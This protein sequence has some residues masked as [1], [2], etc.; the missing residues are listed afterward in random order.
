MT[1]PIHA[2]TQAQCNRNP[3]VRSWDIRE[4]HRRDVLLRTAY[5][6]IVAAFACRPSPRGP[7]D[8][9]ATGDATPWKY[10]VVPTRNAIATALYIGNER[11][12]DQT[13]DA[14]CAFCDQLKADF[15][16]MRPAKEEGS[17]VTLALL[18]AECSGS[19]QVEAMRL[20]SS[21]TAIEAERAIQPL[22]EEESALMRL[23]NRVQRLAR[24]PQMRAVAR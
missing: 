12:V 17:V 22:I 10:I 2:S 9:T 11:L 5:L 8:E 15:A 13:I 14:A 24:E 6:K 3:R 21:P 7:W 1:Q 16:S 20:V 23:I 19:V 4:E 18:E